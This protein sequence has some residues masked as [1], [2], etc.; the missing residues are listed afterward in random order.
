[1][2]AFKA[3]QIFKR[4]RNEE[5]GL[6]AVE[7]AMIFP[8]ML[9]MML[10]IVDVGNAILANQKTVRA[11][12]VVADLISRG[13]GVTQDQID[14]AVTAG[15]LAFEPLNSA[16]Y[17]VDIVSIRFDDDSNGQIVWRETVNMPGVA[18]PLTSTDSL[19]APNEGTVMVTVKYDFVPLFGNFIL[20]ELTM[21]EVAFARGRNSSVVNLN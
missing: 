9:L 7:A 3:F 21:Q 11:S 10:G 19:A 17:G 8:L 5:D 16:S 6:A 14:E 12:Q 1:M 13:S 20:S 4:W 18:D 2:R 15:R